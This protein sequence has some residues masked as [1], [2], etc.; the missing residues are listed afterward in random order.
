MPDLINPLLTDTTSIPDIPLQVDPAQWTRPKVE[1]PEILTQSQEAFPPGDITLSQFSQTVKDK[2]TPI[3]IQQKRDEQAAMSQL[4]SGLQT[5]AVGPATRHF[6]S[7]DAARYKQNSRLWEKIGFNPEVPQDINDA[8]YEHSETTWES[9]KNVIP[10]LWSTTSF[11]FKNYFAEYADAASAI[12]QLHSNLF[13]G[14]SESVM[15]KLHNSTRFDIYANELKELD[16][17]HPDYKSGIDVKWHDYLN[18]LSGQFGDAWEESGSSLGFTLGTIGAALAENAAVTLATAGFGEIA[19]IPNTG[20]KV[21]KAISD[22]YS[23]KRAYS[24]VKGVVGARSIIG[25]IGNAAN[26]WRLTNGALAEAAFEGATNSKEYQDKFREDFIAANGYAP[27]EATMARAK[28]AGDSM[29]NATIL[30]Q[31]PFLMASNAI[32]FGNLIAPKT[33][34]SLSKKFG[35]SAAFKLV[36]KGVAEGFQTAVEASG[37][38]VV[39]GGIRGTASKIGGALRNSLWEGTEESYQALV[40]KSTSD[41]YNDKFFNKD[42]ASIFKGLGAGFDYVTSNEGMKEFA[43]GFATGSIFKGASTALNHFAKPMLRPPEDV[44]KYEQ[45]NPNASETN[46][47]YKLNKLNK[48]FGVGM[49]DVYKEDERARWEKIAATLNQVD[50]DKFLRADGFLDMVRDKKTALALAKYMENGDMFNMRNAQ[51]LQLNRFLFNGLSTGKIDM[52]IDKLAQFAGQDFDV[53]KDYFGLNE[54]DYLTQEDR[55]NFMSSVQGFVG[56]LKDKSKQFEKIYNNQ[57]DSF[58]HVMMKAAVTHDLNTRIQ[59]L[60]LQGLFMKYNVDNEAALEAVI[61]PD[62]KSKHV[63]SA[64]NT[65]ESAMRFHSINDALKASVLAQAGM[66]SDAVAAKNLVKGL[67]AN[68]TSGLRFHD[69]GDLFTKEFRNRQSEQLESKLQLALDSNSPELT[70]IQ[71]QVDAFNKITDLLDGEF[72]EAKDTDI[73]QVASSMQDYLYSIQREINKADNSTTLDTRI[74]QE[75]EALLKS[76]REWARLQKQYQENLNLLNYLADLDNRSEYVDYQSKKLREFFASAAAL[77]EKEKEEAEAAAQPPA[78]VTPPAPATP[79]PAGPEASVSVPP[80]PAAPVTTT[81]APGVSTPVASPTPPI[82]PASAPTSKP[83]LGASPVNIKGAWA[84]IVKSVRSGDWDTIN[85]RKNK[86]RTVDAGDVLA[87]A[88]VFINSSANPDIKTQL[89]DITK[90]IVGVDA[91]NAFFSTTEK[92]VAAKDAAVPEPVEVAPPSTKP[93]LSPTIALL[94]AVPITESTTPV[95]E[96]PV[97]EPTEA[98]LTIEEPV[99]TPEETIDNSPIQEPT[100]P[101]EATLTI[102]QPTVTETPKDPVEEM[103]NDFIKAKLIPAGWVMMVQGNAKEGFRFIAQQINNVDSSGNFIQ[104]TDVRTSDSI[105]GLHGMVKDYANNLFPEYQQTALEADKVQ[106]Q[107]DLSKPT[108]INEVPP[109]DNTEGGDVIISLP[110]GTA[111]I[112]TYLVDEAKSKGTFVFDSVNPK[113][114]EGK[115]DDK[116]ILKGV[117][118]PMARKHRAVM[119]FLGEKFANEVDR[120]KFKIKLEYSKNNLD[121]FYRRGGDKYNPLVAMIVDQNG[122]YLFFN[123]DG[124]LTDE[125]NGQKFGIEYEDNY[126]DTDKLNM[127]RDFMA[128]PNMI[129]TPITSKYAN[130]NPK[131]TITTLVANNVPVYG[132]LVMVTSGTL[133]TWNNDNSYNVTTKPSYKMRTVKEMYESGDIE[134]NQIFDIKMDGYYID[135]KYKGAEQRIKIGKPSIFDVKSGLYIPLEGKKLKDVTFMGTPISKDSQLYEVIDILDKQGKIS[136]DTLRDDKTRVFDRMDV[137]V[138]VFNFLRALIYQQNFDISLSAD[139]ETIFLKRNLF[140][141]KA[142]SIWDAPI[143][144]MVAHGP[145]INIPFTR[146]RDEQGDDLDTVLSYEDFLNE[147]FTSG[148][149]PA[150]ITPSYKGFTK[151]NRRILFQLDQSHETM[152]AQVNTSVQTVNPVSNTDLAVGDL[153]APASNPERVFKITATEDDDLTIEEQNIDEP[154]EKNITRA[155]A[156]KLWMKIDRVKRAPEVVSSSVQKETLRKIRNAPFTKSL[157]SVTSLARPTN[158]PKDEKFTTNSATVAGNVIDHIA[159]N[160]FM[161]N[162]VSFTDILKIGRTNPVTAAIGE[163]FTGEPAFDAAVERIKLIKSNMEERGLTFKTDIRVYDDETGLGGEIDLVAVD[164]DGLVTIYDFK[165]SRYTF[166]KDHMDSSRDGVSEREYFA[167]QGLVYGKMLFKGLGVPINPQVGVIGLPILSKGD[168]ANP[169][170]VKISELTPITNHEIMLNPSDIADKYKGLDSL[171]DIVSKF[172]EILT[173]TATPADISEQERRLGKRKNNNPGLSRTVIDM[174]I[175]AASS[176]ELKKEIEDMSRMFGEDMVVDFVDM[177]NRYEYGVWTTNGTTLY[178]NAIKGTGYHEGWHQ[179]SQLYLTIPQKLS[180]YKALRDEKFDYVDRAGDKRNTGNDNDL[181]I[182]E[183]LADEWAK[184]AQTPKDYKYP[185]KVKVNSVMSLFKRMWQMIKNF[186]SPNKTPTTLFSRL[187][188]GNLKYEKDINNALFRDLT[189]TIVDRDGLEVINHMRTPLYKEATSYFI[190]VVLAKKNRSFTWLRNHTQ[191]KDLLD[192]I[193][194]EYLDLLDSRVAKLI[195][196]TDQPIVEILNNPQEVIDRTVKQTGMKPEQA[197]QYVVQV[198]EIDNIT[199]TGND[200]W[201]K[202]MQWYM[203]NSD[204]DGIIDGSIMDVENHFEDDEIRAVIERQEEFSEIEEEDNND[205]EEGQSGKGERYDR[206]PNEESAFTK[207]SKDVKDFFRTMP[208][209]TGV[210]D[211]GTYQYMLNELGLPYTHDYASIFNKAKTILAG[212]FTEETM[213]KALKNPILLEDFPQARYIA[214][215]LQKYLDHPTAENFAFFMRFKKIMQLPEVDNR[216]LSINFDNL[217][218]N[219]DQKKSIIRSRSLSRSG[220]MAE[221]ESWAHAFS[222][223]TEGRQY[224]DANGTTSTNEMF[225]STDPKNMLY[226]LDGVVKINPFFDWNSQTDK[227]TRQFLSIMGINLNEGFWKSDVAIL[228]DRLKSHIIANLNDYSLYVKSNLVRDANY[229]EAEYK[230][231][232]ADTEPAE[233]MPFLYNTYFISNPITLFRERKT[234]ILDKKTYATTSIHTSLEDVS[235][236]NSVFSLTASSRSFTDGSGKMKWPFYNISLINY[237]TQ[238]LNDVQNISDFDSTNNPEF[239]SLDPNVSPWLKQS[240]FYKAQFDENGDRYTTSRNVRDKQGNPYSRE[241]VEIQL[242]DLSSYETVSDKKYTRVHP[243]SLSGQDKMFF[244][245]VTLL[246]EGFIEISRA[247][248]SSSIMA[249]KLNSYDARRQGEGYKKQFLPIDLATVSVFRNDRFTS[250][251]TGYLQAELMKMKYYFDQNPNAENTALKMDDPARNY[252][253]H[254]LNIFKDILKEDLPQKLISEVQQSNGSEAAIK[255]IVADNKQQFLGQL[256]KYFTEY[257][258]NIYDNKENPFASSLTKMSKNQKSVLKN[259]L[260]LYS[261]VSKSQ[262][263]AD[264]RRENEAE[265]VLAERGA[266]SSYQNSKE[267]AVS[268]KDEPLRIVS[269]LFAANQFILNVEYHT[270]YMGDSYL[271]SNPFKRGKLTTNTGDTAIV[272]PFMNAALNN[273]KGQTMHS[274]VSGNNPTKDYRFLKTSVIKDNIVSS[275][276]FDNMVNDIINIEK[277]YNTLSNQPAAIERRREELKKKF[278]SYTKINSADGQSKMSLDAYRTLRRVYGTWD[279]VKDENEYQRQLAILRLHLNRYTGKYVYTNSEGIG[280]TDKQVDQD[281]VKAGP[282]KDG[283]WSEFNP[284]KFSYTG[285]EVAGNAPMRTKFDKTS[286]QPLLPEMLVGTG[287]A[288]E[289]LMMQM[290]QNDVDYVKFESV[291]K[292][293]KHGGVVD[294]F[295]KEGNQKSG[296]KL[297]DQPYENLLS[298]YFKH[299]LSTDGMHTENIFGSQQRV[300]FFDVKYQPEVQNNPALLKQITDLEDRYLSS[301]KNVMDFQKTQFLNRFG[302]IEK[303]NRAGITSMEIEDMDRFAAAINSIA[304]RDNFPENMKEYLKYDPNSKEY[305]YD[306]SLLFNRKMLIDS[307]GGLIDGEMRRMRTKG[308]AAIQASQMGSSATKFK[309]P[310]DEQL[311]KYGSAGLHYYHII[312]DENGKPIRTSTMGIKITMQGDYE[313]LLNL[314]WKDKKIGTVER[315]NEAMKDESWKKTHMSKFTLLG[316]RIPTNNN[317]FI[318]H[319]EIMEFLPRSTGNIVIAPIEHIIKSGSD[320]DVDKMNFVFPTIGDDGELLTKPSDDIDQINKKLN[321]ITPSVFDYKKDQRDLN[322]LIQRTNKDYKR[323]NK[324]RDAAGMRIRRAFSDIDSGVYQSMEDRGSSFR[325][326]RDYFEPLVDDF[327]KNHISDYDVLSNYIVMD[328]KNDSKVDQ[329]FKQLL[330]A[331]NNYKNFYVNEML[332]IQKE[333]LSNPSY[334]RIMVS[335]SNTDYLIEQ[336]ERIGGLANRTINDNLSSTE[337]MK[338]TTISAKFKEYMVDAKA[339]GGFSIQ[340]R[341]FSLLNYSKMYLNRNW[342]YSGKS[343]RIYTPLADVNQRDKLGDTEHINMYG[344]NLDGIP[345]NDIWDQFMSLTIDLPGNTSYSLFG[346]NPANKKVVQY[347]IS[348]RYPISMI[349]SFI[350]QPI[351]NEVYLLHATKSKDFPTYTVKTAMLEVA[352]KYNIR[353]GDGKEHDFSE[354]YDNNWEKDKD[355]IDTIP[356]VYVKNPGIAANMVLNEDVYFTQEDLDRDIKEPIKTDEFR[357][358]QKNILLYFMSANLEATNFS[359][360]QFAFSEDR[361][362][363][364]NYFTISEN[365]DKKEGIRGKEDDDLAPDGSMF[366]KDG[367]TK[368]EKDSIYTPFRYGKVASTFYKVFANEFTDLAVSDT[369]KNILSSTNTFGI[370]RQLLATR[371][372]GDFVEFIYKNFATFAINTYDPF[373]DKTAPATGSFSDYFLQTIF[374]IKKDPDYKTYGEKLTKFLQKYPELNNIPFINKLYPESRLGKGKTGEEPS[375]PMDL[376]DFNVLRFKRSQENTISERNHYSSELKNLISFN[377]AEFRLTQN[378]S[379]EDITNISSF[380]TEL[381]YLTLY[382]AGPTNI[383]DNFS[384]LIPVGI[385]QEF[386]TKAFANY[387]KAVPIEKKDDLM[388]LFHMLYTHNNPKVP[389]RGA[390]TIYNM[391]YFGRKLDKEESKLARPYRQPTWFATNYRAGKLYDIKGISRAIDFNGLNDL[392][393]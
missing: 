205:D 168:E 176:E 320:F 165:S 229:S 139:N 263:S 211:D 31:T 188:T 3:Q 272:S 275:K 271:F 132:S 388:K 308:T 124:Q 20:R 183:F 210:N 123:E 289:E 9:F 278:N 374:N 307:I 192:D 1:I 53:L 381:A 269:T 23:I 273:M 6:S 329:E 334:Y 141:R 391:N 131:S 227:S 349:M 173:Q 215:K 37:K 270:W 372:E 292:G 50:L 57:K 244:D 169:Y 325:E 259:V 384:D 365:D 198:Q 201:K 127:S 336:A 393:C 16:A 152:L 36:N 110:A 213:M 148:A 313:N 60:E 21:F 95:E 56:S 82:P 345:V 62:D 359:G 302:M 117:K 251:M 107:T 382:Q 223:P 301:I 142:K 130:D 249:V 90:D 330:K 97:S 47:K 118:D 195:T 284:Q 68:N 390:T 341:W 331:L 260:N 113:E 257:A 55:N 220:E 175:A 146:Q 48:V 347:L 67:A 73:D 75:R 298:S 368:L 12:G 219:V 221:I 200:A 343:M 234:F 335:P 8:M 266:S 294:F 353:G 162:K 76:F 129:G 145:R 186:F 235:R 69:I 315:L 103:M 164:K 264:Q 71:A 28:K 367:L 243:K 248:N 17:L 252:F 371:I 100:D 274:I 64:A 258:E 385:W 108:P 22:Y 32:Q 122:K 153:I 226:N 247:S 369:I 362:K 182:E 299:Q 287:S 245:M 161:G 366:S 61:S 204:I 157:I 240:L 199:N 338:Y 377:P 29:A 143:N 116:L 58:G 318:D 246:H 10:K 115:D 104:G 255:K 96:L 319:A 321:S 328:N 166:D 303:T 290:A 92:P 25:K 93:I 105:K 342:K 144:Y 88:S 322:N 387:N 358:R 51:N 160:I 54:D 346:I 170:N 135:Y 98:T 15:N 187:Y 80:A 158:K 214:D 268:G 163:Y 79:P 149:V 177:M 293:V 11:A 85:D 312:Y 296:V 194:D 262:S 225:S 386:S 171:T 66:E 206:A 373:A 128:S 254:N 59:N 310:T 91:Y 228:A 202:F 261:D 224:T 150:Q 324:M 45:E 24:L 305:R 189:A 233:N 295:D 81:V 267:T 185:G 337:N 184:Y 265:S 27:D 49:A 89:E 311:K 351:L 316:Y 375:N 383:A 179:F 121:N 332:E 364:T 155:A 84:A 4:S 209:I 39:K 376:F 314:K 238:I 120:D 19:E 239:T 70:I 344:D 86:L 279:E 137:M 350:N 65:T 370:D 112:V 147:N 94:N 276:Y 167:T 41:Y 13:N 297:E 340:R 357:N 222:R 300:M 339:L 317:N 63:Q 18:P 285:P 136:L 87:S 26:L 304:K 78:P 154:E 281:L 309:N 379:E 286:F 42:E 83:P 109:P 191:S 326:M 119:S 380:F 138:D 282:R 140:S 288:D 193:Y 242:A 159:K 14:T 181:D 333:T 190:G 46:K 203:A 174:S 237:R 230:A 356:N 2:L 360:M 7:T 389:W 133:S 253:A 38:E 208:I 232:T 306:P 180:L 280:V 323:A 196:V 361:N 52:Q 354:L 348:S 291:T 217:K 114:I 256:T 231:F 212:K 34:A 99:I 156:K 101:A 30:F 378:Y 134:D 172:K 102:E 178:N 40:T 241:K 33:V 250:I 327:T 43:A 236:Q 352:K 218:N 5:N 35:Q 207:A 44:A 277:A 72:D 392:N 363:N 126:Y 216:K 197:R 74:E 77:T 283:S 355:R 125:E 106:L 111:N 151:V